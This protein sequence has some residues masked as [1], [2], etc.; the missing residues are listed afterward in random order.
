MNNYAELRNIM[1]RKILPA[2][3]YVCY[4]CGGIFNM[5]MEPSCKCQGTEPGVDFDFLDPDDHIRKAYIKA[6]GWNA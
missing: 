5:D 3:V 4:E 1:T 6:Q 2:L